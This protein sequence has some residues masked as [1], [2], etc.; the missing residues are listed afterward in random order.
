MSQAEALLEKIS[1]IQRELELLK[2][3]VL[4]S[5]TLHGKIV[6]LYGAVKGA[7]VTDKMITKAKKSLFREL[8]DL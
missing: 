1:Q 8:K 2:R 4:K 6:S 5:A 3:D 7:D